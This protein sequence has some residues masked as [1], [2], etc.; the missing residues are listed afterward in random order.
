MADKTK[1]AVRLYRFKNRLKE[2]V[3][4]LGGGGKPQISAEALAEAEAALE[5]MSEDY[6]DWVSGLIDR[7]AEQHRRCVDT[8][9]D[10]R[11]FFEEISDIAHDMKGQGGTFGYPL[12]SSFAES[13]NKFSYSKGELTDNH[14][15]LI[16]AH[17]DS[18]R[19]VITGRVKGDGGEIGIELSK[20]LEKAIQKFKAR[21][22]QSASTAATG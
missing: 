2:Q 9:E 17:V 5:A 15:E 10:R 13:L 18:M 12:I 22:G 21:E 19:A 6:P 16:K 3:S 8:S 11:F 4:G 1:I 7:L 14:V 20:G